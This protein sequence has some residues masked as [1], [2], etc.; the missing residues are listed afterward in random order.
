MTHLLWP[1]FVALLDGSA[2]VLAVALLVLG[3]L[4]LFSDRR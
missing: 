1:V 4:V 2:L 3:A